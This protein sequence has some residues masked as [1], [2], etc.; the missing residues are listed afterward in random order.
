MIIDQVTNAGAVPVLEMVVRFAGQR[1]RLIAHNVANIST[2]D[3]RPVDA[4][5]PEFQRML[6]RAIEERRG[7]NGGTHG[8]LAWEPSR[9]LARGSRGELVVSGR[10]PSGGILFQDRNDRDLERLMQSVAENTAAFRLATDLLRQQTGMM[11]LAM[12][13]RVA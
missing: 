13:E 10:T 1:Q 11:R 7:R 5:V 3:F 8:A 12:S 2:P 9:E 6:G 4:S